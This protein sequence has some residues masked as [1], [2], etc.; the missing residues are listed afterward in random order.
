MKLTRRQ[1]VAGAA[2]AALGAAGIY[3]LADQ[4]AGSPARTAAMP[5]GPPLGG[6]ARPRRHSDREAGRRRGDRPAASPPRRDRDGEARDRPCEGAAGPRERAARARVPVR[7]DTRRARAHR[8]LGPAVLRPPRRRGRREASPLRPA[9]PEVGAARHASVPERPARHRPG[10]ERRR[11]AHPERPA[12]PHRGRPEDTAGRPRRLRDA[13]DPPPGVRRRRSAAEARRRRGR[14]RCVPDP[15]RFRAV[16]RLH[17][18]AE[19]RTRTPADRE[20]RDAR[21]CRSSRRLLPRRHAHAPVAH[22]RG[23]RGL[24]PQLR[25]PGARRHR[26]SGPG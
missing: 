13:H 24:V 9:R 22:L 6:T 19:G 11:A 10:G 14:P 18:D 3:E 21:P 1:L 23:P 15:A 5:L 2:G 8:R 12:R 17:L 7:A 26:R 4:L 20:L 16:P 25:V